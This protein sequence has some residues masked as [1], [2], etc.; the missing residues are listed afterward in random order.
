MLY[1]PR[2]AAAKTLVCSQHCF[3]RKSRTQHHEGC[4]EEN[5]LPSKQTQYKGLRVSGHGIKRNKF[6]IK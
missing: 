4:C 6:V 5:K 3:G 2:S 1:K